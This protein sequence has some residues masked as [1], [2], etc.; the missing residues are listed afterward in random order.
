VSPVNQYLTI[1]LPDSVSGLL[2][3]ELH[4]LQGGDPVAPKEEAQIV[5]LAGEAQTDRFPVMHDGGVPQRAEPRGGLQRRVLGWADGEAGAE[6]PL[7]GRIG[8]GS[9][10]PAG[11]LQKSEPSAVCGLECKDKRVAGNS[12]AN[13]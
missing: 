8:G 13:L 7:A 2:L 5:S 12:E 10:S 6:G 3:S 4:D 9:Y 1:H 11:T